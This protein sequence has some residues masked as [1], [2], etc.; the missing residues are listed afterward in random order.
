MEDNEEKE[1]PKRALYWHHPDTGG[2][3]LAV[4]VSS[5][6][7]NGDYVNDV[8]IRFEGVITNVVLER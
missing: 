8:V 4:R 1:A 7:G 5:L 2:G 3:Y 6:D